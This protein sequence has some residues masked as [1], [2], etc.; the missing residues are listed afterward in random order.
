[1]RPGIGSAV[2][3][4]LLLLPACQWR[5]SLDGQ[6]PADVKDTPA[7]A[8]A[9]RTNEV[10]EANGLLA[11]V[12]P[13]AQLERD[14]LA[15]RPIRKLGSAMIIRSGTASLEI[16]TLETAIDRVRTLASRVGGYLANSDIQAV[17]GGVRSA[18]IEIKVPS[19]RFDELVNGLSPLGG[20]NR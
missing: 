8:P 4:T 10:G 11:D 7:S 17:Q 19:D 1:M 6:K 15:Y 20:W 2:L 18:T 3:L 13:S 16:D 9:R 14:R 5:A 12:R